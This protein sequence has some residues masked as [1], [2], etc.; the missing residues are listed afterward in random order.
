MAKIQFKA[1]PYTLYFADG[2]LAGEYVKI[3][4]LRHSHCDMPAMRTHEIYGDYANS[5]IWPSVLG[6]IR[7]KISDG[8]NVFD[9]R[10]LPAGVTVA[11]SGFL[12]TV[13]IEV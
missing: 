6:G 5:D 7:K 12:A 10:Q 2:S 11:V 4:V 1:R 9:L 13:T 3:P 8:K